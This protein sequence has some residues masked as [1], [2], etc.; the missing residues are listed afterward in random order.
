MKIEDQIKQVF[1]KT[2]KFFSNDFVTLI[3]GS[4]LAVLLM[5][6]IITIPP[7]VFGIY[8]MCIQ[9]TKGKEIKVSDIF[10]GFDYFFRSWGIFILGF[11][12]ILL[13]LILLIIPGILLM[14]LWQFVI[15]IAIAENKGVIASLGRSYDLGK[16]N[17][18]FSIV[19]FLIIIVIDSIGG[20]TRI[21]SLI[22]IPFGILATCV[23]VQ[24]LSK[25]KKSSKMQS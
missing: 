4:L 21:G 12:G 18:A 15:V 17:F 8:Y 25:G 3:L 14:I 6:F 20:W 2:W 16:K 24:M 7:M 23:A 11:L 19:F 22:T 13:G 9:L 1:V 5:I 10:K